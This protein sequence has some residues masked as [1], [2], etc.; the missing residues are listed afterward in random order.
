MILS[1]AGDNV[2]YSDKSL[3]ITK[4]VVAGLNKA[5]KPAKAAEPAKA[6]EKK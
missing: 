6:E 2:L 4:E 1:K 5:Y 3:D